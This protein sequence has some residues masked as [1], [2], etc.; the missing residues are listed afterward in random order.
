MADA[1][2]VIELVFGAIDEVT[3]V[4]DKMNKGVKGVAGSVESVIGPIANMTATLLALEAGL[5]AAGIAAGSFALK[6]SSEFNTSFAEINTLLHAGEQDVAD[7]RDE[8]QQFASGSS[9]AFGDVTKA[10]YDAISAG[11][12]YKD[13][14]DF[15][16]DAERLAVAGRA[17][18]ASTTNLLTSALNAY[19]ASTDEAERFSDAFFKTVELGKTTI[20]ELASALG[21]VA[22]TASAAGVSVEEL[23]AAI[24]VVTARGLSTDETITGLKA[25]I[26]NLIKPGSD[27]AKIAKEMGLSFDAATLQSKGLEG[28]LQ[29]IIKATGGNVD[30]IKKLFGSTEALNVVL[31]LVDNSASKYNNTLGKIKDSQ[32]ATATAADK[33]GQTLEITAQKMQNAFKSLQITIG[34]ELEGSV[35]KVAKSIT[36]LFTALEQSVKQ[37]SFDPLIEAAQRTLEVF[38]QAISDMAKVIPDA[39]AGVDFGPLLNSLEELGASFS[40]VT[41]EIDLTTVDGLTAAFQ[42]LVNVA[43]HLVNFTTGVVQ[44]FKAVFDVLGIFIPDITKANTGLSEVAGTIGGVALALSVTLLPALKLATGAVDVMT[45]SVKLGKLAY[46]NLGGAAKAASSAVSLLASAG[47]V[48]I[49][50]AIGTAAVGA[51][52]AING[53]EGSL[54]RAVLASVGLVEASDGLT[55]RL[56]ELTAEADAQAAALKEQASAQTEAEL[57]IRETN[58]AIEQRIK[59]LEEVLGGQEAFNAATIEW[60]TGAGPKFFG[61]LT[62]SEQ[63]LRDHALEA[64]Y[65][66]LGIRKLGDT[67]TNLNE[68]GELL[69]DTTNEAALGQVKYADSALA[70]EE[71]ARDLQIE[72]LD[73]AKTFGINGDKAA[74]LIQKTAELELEWA[75][76]AS[77]ERQLFFE[78]QADLH[79]AELEA[80][81]EQFK[82]VMESLDTT[83]ESTGETL[84]GLAELFAGTDNFFDQNEI[85][86][87]LEDE[88]RRRQEALDL[89]KKIVEEQVRYLQ[90]MTQRLQNGDSLISI[91][92]DGLEP[93]LQAF[94][95]KIL[96]KVQIEA[97]AQGQAFLLGLPQV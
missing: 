44:G 27:A 69:K 75:K 21:R 26:Q 90:A 5:V 16:R 85:R 86:R 31:A 56:R 43:D 2:K 81:T 4:L 3:P 88:N 62:D 11:V 20:P 41:G 94:M 92:A 34:T 22:P 58:D 30:E 46:D 65:A 89:Q 54:T 57:S 53:W 63:A 72:V 51:D 7:F 59:A 64:E 52:I 37:G 14:V 73:L 17:D 82:A 79:I 40:S 74:D 60:S 42:A 80:Q 68:A 36:E 8:I 66:A 19:G 78:V 61:V 12:D 96:E 76:L 91:T 84:L 50:A 23:S 6:A 9:F 49:I 67:Y 1:R 33:M 48:A 35:A 97:S 15:I 70:A 13:S 93:E 39:I 47:P 87:L 28:V 25:T 77:E 95:F 83:I 71:R 32:G 45:S 24:A 29:D 55:P 18:L 38:A 10:V